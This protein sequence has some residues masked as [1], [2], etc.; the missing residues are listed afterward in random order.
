MQRN[1]NIIFYFN[2]KV[3]LNITISQLNSDMHLFCYYLINKQD[4]HSLKIFII[5][6]LKLKCVYSEY[7]NKDTERVIFI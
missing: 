3:I 2:G 4:I 7:A 6:T 1:K 5:K